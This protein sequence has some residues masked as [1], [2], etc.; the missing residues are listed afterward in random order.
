MQN[1]TF[2]QGE[3]KMNQ[4][5]REKIADEFRNCVDGTIERITNNNQTYRP[6]HTAL[7]SEDAIFWSAFE[8]SFSTSFGQRVIEE[9]AKLVALSNGADAA[10]RQKET[11]ISIDTAYEDAI[12]HYMLKLREKNN[13]VAREWEPAL[14]G[15]L[16]TPKTGQVTTIRVIS[17][18]WWRKNGIDN[19]IS[20]KT[21]K[22]NI[23]QTAVAKEDCLHLK[24]ADP[25][26]NAYFGLPYN[27]YGENK[28][29]YAHN[30]PMGIFDFRHDS[31]VLIGKEMWNTIGGDGCYNELL[32]IAT[33]VG[34]E[35]REKIKQ[36]HQ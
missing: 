30:P 1:I 8:R 2:K 21:V 17:D 5:Y 25:N 13:D 33:Q 34:A 29:D 4:Y 12:H 14:N 27:P 28:E 20:L 32:D 7:L 3:R 36:M 35:T 15:I 31:V 6:F 19:Y 18:M 11:M 9:I 23:D 10:E 16:S 22:P 24:V 26:C